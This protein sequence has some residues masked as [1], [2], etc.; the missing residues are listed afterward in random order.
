MTTM[1]DNTVIVPKAQGVTTYAEGQRVQIDANPSG[2]NRDVL[3]V[4]Q[5][6]FGV[7]EVIQTHH[8]NG[9]GLVKLDVT[10]YLVRFDK[11]AGPTS[12]GVT[13]SHFWFDDHDIR[14]VS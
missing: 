4:M 3:A 12:R 9:R 11:P 8:D 10:R 14:G 13:M 2:W 6:Q 1:T 7:V 5:G